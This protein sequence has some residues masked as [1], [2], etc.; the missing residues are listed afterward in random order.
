M[1]LCLS[2]LEQNSLLCTYCPNK[3]ISVLPQRRKIYL[4]NTPSEQVELVEHEQ[5]ELVD[6]CDNKSMSEITLS[7][8]K[9]C[10]Q[11]SR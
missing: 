8:E 10:Y 5:E 6:T 3:S 9:F 11:F 4:S 7:K 2:T 1:P